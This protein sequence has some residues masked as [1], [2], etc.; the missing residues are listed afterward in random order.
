MPKGTFVTGNMW[1]THRNPDIYDHPD[2][3][4]ASRWLKENEKYGSKIDVKES[5]DGHIATERRHACK[6]ITVSRTYLPFGVGKY[7]W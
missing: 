6:M 4:D 2:E 5:A 1:A 7:A 3:F